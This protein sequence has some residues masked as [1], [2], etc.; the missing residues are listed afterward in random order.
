MEV[1]IFC[2]LLK[3]IGEVEFRDGLLSDLI[4][5]VGHG[6]RFYSLYHEC[7]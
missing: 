2:H 6:L 3:A 4:V 1:L 5:F 7:T